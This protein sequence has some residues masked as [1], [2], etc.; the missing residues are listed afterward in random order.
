MEIEFD[1]G[2]VL[3]PGVEQ[4]PRPINRIRNPSDAVFLVFM[5]SSLG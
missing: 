4:S 1:P 5:A 3:D 2:V